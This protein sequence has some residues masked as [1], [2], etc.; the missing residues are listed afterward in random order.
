MAMDTK[1]D[2]Q[3]SHLQYP[4]IA[5]ALSGGGFRAAIFHLGVL[6]RIA[7]IGLLRRIDLVSTVSGGSILGA[8]M[9]LKWNDVK[10]AGCDWNSFNRYVVQPFLDLVTNSNFIRRWAIRLPLV[11]IRKLVDR[12]Y[13]RTKLAAELFDRD[14]YEEARCDGLPTQPYLILNATSLVSIRAWRF[15]RD[16]HGDSRLGHAAWEGKPLPLGEAVGASAAFP[17]VFTPARIRISDYNFSAPIYGESKL[18]DYEFIALSD[19]GV[20][21]NLG[22][23][24]LGKESI[25]PGGVGKIG[26][27]EFVVVSDAGYPAQYHFHSSGLPGLGEGLL[28]YRVDAIAREQAIALRRRELVKG[29]ID[30]LDRRKGLLVMLGSHI[31]KLPGRGANEYRAT[32]GSDFCIPPELL[33]RIRTIRTH[34]DRF[35]RVECNALMY[36][37]YTMTDALLWYYRNG[38]PEPYRVPETP[39]PQWRIEF[40]KS[41][42][43]QWAEELQN[44]NRQRI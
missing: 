29:F 1:I 42:T 4:R 38:F 44:S 13:T 25:L 10:A 34:L 23:E 35:T 5:L 36:H 18:P 30:P 24:V 7:E 40:T 8:F 2:S 3:L 37:A 31:G 16:G 28:L 33:E 15:T 27:P 26:I 20:Y 6:R 43:K 12:T 19:G 32:V 39:N 41:T 21:D 22:L 17:P 14:F 9:A 11:P